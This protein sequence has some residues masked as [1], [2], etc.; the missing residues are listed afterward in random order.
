MIKSLLISGL[1]LLVSSSISFAQAKKI[2]G[3]GL[4]GLYTT[5]TVDKWAPIRAKIFSAYGGEIKEISFIEMQNPEL[6]GAFLVSYPTG[7]IFL[8]SDEKT[9]SAILK[10]LPKIFPDFASEPLDEYKDGFAITMQENGTNFSLEGTVYKASDKPQAKSGG[11]LTINFDDEN[12]VT[13]P[14]GTK[15]MMQ[16][17]QA[18]GGFKI[19]SFSL[20]APQSKDSTADF[21]ESQ[22]DAAGIKHEAMKNDQMSRF[23]FSVNGGPESQITVIQ[24]DGEPD[25]SAISVWVATETN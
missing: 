21:V 8:L 3:E 13:F 17:E 22:L 1:V 24:V 7:E 20:S 16:S 15:V 5:T 18:D 12:K 9:P 2:S 6:K 19:Q 4:D 11:A 23:V 25:T 10:L 14:E